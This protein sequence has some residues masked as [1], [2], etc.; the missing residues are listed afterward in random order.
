MNFT[1]KPPGFAPGFK[2]GYQTG[3]NQAV[4]SIWQVV[5]FLM[6]VSLL[7]WIVRLILNRVEFEKE[8]ILGNKTILLTPEKCY[9][10]LTDVF[11]S[12][13]LTTLAFLFAEHFL[14]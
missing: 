8:V 6:A 9:F 5:A 3:I 7:Y 1:E 2:E 13:T 4:A 14:V 10:I 11:Y 12:L